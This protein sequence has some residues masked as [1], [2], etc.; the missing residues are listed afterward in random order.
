[1][2]ELGRVKPI[3]TTKSGP[4]VRRNAFKCAARDLRRS[5]ILDKL[6]HCTNTAASVQLL[7]ERIRLKH[8]NQRMTGLNENRADR[9]DVVRA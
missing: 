7:P 3:H 2:S 4:N 8:R 1:M 5:A 6:D 9:V